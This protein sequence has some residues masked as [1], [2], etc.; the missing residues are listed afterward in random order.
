MLEFDSSLRTNLIN[1]VA[2]YAEGASTKPL[3][4]TDYMKRT[5]KEQYSNLPEEDKIYPKQIKIPRTVDEMLKGDFSPSKVITLHEQPYLDD[6]PVW[7]GT[8]TN[9]VNIHLGT[10]NGDSRYPCDAQ[11]NDNY[12]HMLLAGATGSGKSVALNDII[13][14]IALNYAPWEVNLVLCDA[15]ITEFK[16]YAEGSV[17]PHISAVAATSDSDYL[18][19]VL[20]YYYN[21]MLSMCSILPKAGAGIKNIMQFRAHTGLALPRTLIIIDE[22]QTMFKYATTKQ[23]QKITDM[24]DAFARLG[25][26]VGYHVVLCSQ[27]L[28][29]NITKGTLNQI[30]I[31]AALGC[32]ADVSDKILNNDMARYNDGIKGR[33][34]LNRNISASDTKPFNQEHRVPY[35]SDDAFKVYSEVIEQ[36]GK[37]VGFQR[38]LTYYD[39]NSIVL[40]KDYLSY[41]SQ[42]ERNK[43]KIYLGEPSIMTDVF[44]RV[45]TIDYSGKDS[46]NI[47]IVTHVPDFQ[48]RHIKMLKYNISREQ[49]QHVVLYTDKDFYDKT[50]LASL[51]GANASKSHGLIERATESTIYKS[52]VIEGVRY[53]QLMCKVDNKVFS[54]C[55]FTDK[56]DELY[57]ICV[58]KNVI[59][60]SKIYRSRCGYLMEDLISNFL[61]ANRIKEL[62]DKKQLEQLQVK[63][64]KI[65]RRWKGFGFNE[66]KAEPSKMPLTYVWMLGMNKI[67]GIGRDSNA[68][69]YEALKSI[70]QD[71][72]KYNVRFIITTSHFDEGCL[73]LKKS[74][75]W[76]I[77][78]GTL[79]NVHT[80]V[81]SDT[82]PKIVP[83][84]LS[85]LYDIETN[86]CVKYKK[87]YYDDEPIKAS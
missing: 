80:K 69:Q 64:V 42:F 56:G 29:S 6:M 40:E 87:M 74:C 76:F 17:L 10:L 28:D 82:Y 78:E 22:F 14:G 20:E 8:S 59:P 4:F 57:D 75:R 85:V 49:A 12:I 23:K 39:Q 54:R 48:L 50:E 25:R 21:E 62:K 46:E 51:S 72:P 19:S 3:I 44:P 67:I 37:S 27:E 13:F 66:D 68:R 55:D 73:I 61:T 52:G 47:A 36:L 34:I 30:K 35:I 2:S 24:L 9:G 81:T 83:S 26:S 79:D 84:V 15:K 43:N 5:L 60:E 53:K 1:N 41:L 71:G 16:N 11:F 70:L 63:A 38:K 45:K 65:L 18:I 58:A 7:F 77:F 31:R 86:S 32:A 33:C